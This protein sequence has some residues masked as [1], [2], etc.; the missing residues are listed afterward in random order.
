MTALPSPRIEVSRDGA[1][2][3]LAIHPA[4][5]LPATT[6]RPAT[7]ASHASAAREAD[8]LRQ[9]TGWPVIDLSLGKGAA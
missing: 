3:R 5:A 4:D 7:H 1:F 2:Y 9:A 6:M 8:I